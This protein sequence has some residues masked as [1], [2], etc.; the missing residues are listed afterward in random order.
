VRYQTYN[1]ELNLQ[2]IQISKTQSEE[3]KQNKKESFEKKAKRK[4]T[5]KN[6]KVAGKTLEEKKRERN[7]RMLG[8]GYKR[9]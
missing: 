1:P 3:M 8:A 6:P 7:P 2:E 9:S 5:V 4:Q